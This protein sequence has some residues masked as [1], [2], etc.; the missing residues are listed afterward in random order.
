MSGAAI[1]AE[2]GRLPS[3]PMLAW[4]AMPAISLRPRNRKTGYLTQPIM[5]P[6]VSRP[7]ST[8]MPVQRGPLRGLSYGLAVLMIGVALGC[9]A[10]RERVNGVQGIAWL[11]GHPPFHADIVV[12]T[13]L[14]AL[15]LLLRD[16]AERLSRSE[17]HTSELQALMPN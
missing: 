6:D 11:P 13:A 10:G 7:R 14:A 15:A 16:H 12:A 8:N 2:Q 4:P 5:V 1:R 3:R 17:E 9:L